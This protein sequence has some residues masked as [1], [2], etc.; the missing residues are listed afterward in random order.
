MCNVID[1]ED[2]KVLVTLDNCPRNVAK[3]SV[4]R[5]YSPWLTIES[6]IAEVLLFVGVTHAEVIES[7]G[8]LR[9]VEPI[10]LITNP[11]N[12]LRTTM[13]QSEVLWKCDC[14]KGTTLAVIYSLL[15]NIEYNLL[16]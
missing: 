6:K 13:C 8:S 5:I 4:I 3:N 16:V 9:S 15:S 12:W 7:S 1:T 14:S 11:I 2:K 10:G